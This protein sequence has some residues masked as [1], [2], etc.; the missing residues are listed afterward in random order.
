MITSVFWIYDLNYKRVLPLVKEC[1][2]LIWSSSD[3][4][5]MYDDY[6][7]I[8]YSFKYVKPK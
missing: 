4:D 5:D 1:F 6:E 8:Y 7:G 3:G 2:Y